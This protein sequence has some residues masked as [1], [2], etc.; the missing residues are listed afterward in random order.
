M[1][2]VIWRYVESV[3]LHTG[4]LPLELAKNG[5]MKAGS[6]CHLGHFLHTASLYCQAGHSHGGHSSTT[7]DGIGT[8]SAVQGAIYCFRLAYYTVIYRLTSFILGFC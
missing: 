4:T 2:R 7:L 8:Q 5:G 6:C 3:V 1:V